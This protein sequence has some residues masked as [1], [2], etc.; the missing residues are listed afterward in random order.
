MIRIE[1][2]AWQIRASHSCDKTESGNGA[3]QGGIG[4]ARVTAQPCF[5]FVRSVPLY[6][7]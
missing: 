4:G 2:R 7:F 5:E 3:M 1:F 6:C